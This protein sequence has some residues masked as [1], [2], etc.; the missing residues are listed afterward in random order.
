M[1]NMV[2]CAAICS[3]LAVKTLK[4]QGYWH[5]RL[6]PSHFSELEGTV[7]YF[8]GIGMS[9]WIGIGT[10]IWHLPEDVVAGKHLVPIDIVKAV[11]SGHCFCF[12]TSVQRFPE[13]VVAGEH[14]VPIEVVKAFEVVFWGCHAHLSWAFNAFFGFVTIVLWSSEIYEQSYLR[15]C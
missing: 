2:T 8:W 1:I 6:T 13:D 11:L 12:G 3:I 7:G 14:L 4:K 5:K 9:I 15:S 10:R